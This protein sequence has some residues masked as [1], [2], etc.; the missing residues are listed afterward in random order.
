M[1][2]DER[3]RLDLCTAFHEAGHAW[4]YMRAHKPLRYITIRPRAG[5]GRPG[6]GVCRTWKPRRIDVGQGAWISAAGPVAEAIWVQQ[7]YPGDDLDDLTFDDHLLGAV[8]PVAEKTSIT[9]SA[10]SIRRASSRP[11][12]SAC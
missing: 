7:E 12:A 4:A 3:Q 8:L 11:Y 1:G 10:C 9:H 5:A 6:H 2:T